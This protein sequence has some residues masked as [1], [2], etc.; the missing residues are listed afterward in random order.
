MLTTNADQPFQP[1]TMLCAADFS[2]LSNLALKYAAAGALAYGARLVV[3][4][5]S[6]F[7]PPRYFTP[8]Q[9]EA[10]QAQVHA[11]AGALEATLRQHVQAVLGELAARLNISFRIVTGHAVDGVLATAAEEKAGLIVM[12]THGRGGGRRLWL[13][14]VA[15]NVVRQAEVPVAVVRQKQHEFIDAARPESPLRLQTILC[16]VNA[17]PVA[18]MAL[19]VAASIAGA[20]QARLISACAIEPGARPAGLSSANT[21][22]WVRDLTGNACAVDFRE[23]HGRAA[24][25]I[26]ALAQEAK[27]DL[28]VLGAQR[29]P[30]LGSW[31]WGDTTELVLRH[32]P[33][34]VLVV[35]RTGVADGAL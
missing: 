21:E 11:A 32:A 29:Q 24:E 25:E 16:P 4:H 10:L 18:R 33:V 5:A 22:A 15:E 14:S 7:E 6:H 31:L 17:T 12:G 34:P 28:I 1:A 23:R 9:I 30:S 2:E 13:G 3:L 8:G 35:P 26:V 27:A 20:F 19:R